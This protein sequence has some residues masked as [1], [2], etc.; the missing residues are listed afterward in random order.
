[1][2]NQNVELKPR[3]TRHVVEWICKGSPIQGIYSK[4]KQKWRKRADDV[5]R[6]WFGSIS[7]S[8]INWKLGRN[9][10]QAHCSYP[11]SKRLPGTWSDLV[12]INS[13][14][15]YNEGQLIS[16]QLRTFYDCHKFTSPFFY[17]SRE[18]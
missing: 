9:L 2:T 12:H 7:I 15:E 3:G 1:M 11:T 16:K 14:L 13:P 10:E 8:F 5:W 4:A 6:A 18:L 17:F